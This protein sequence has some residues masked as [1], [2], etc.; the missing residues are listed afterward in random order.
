MD[1]LRINSTNEMSGKLCPSFKCV[2]NSQMLG[3]RRNDGSIAILPKPLKLPDDFIETCR[4]KEVNPNEHFRFTGPCHE[5]SC[6]QWQNNHCSIIGSA[7]KTVN[8]I[9]ENIN[10]LPPCQIRSNCQ[11]Y[12]QEKGAACK[13][14]AFIVNEI[15]EVNP[16]TSDSL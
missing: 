16:K 4:K 15:S 12:F 5:G 1:L 7:V 13:S 9:I 10:S 11:W 8:K 3:V 6:K 14:C 2:P